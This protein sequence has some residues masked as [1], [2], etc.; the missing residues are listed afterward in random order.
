MRR[1]ALAMIACGLAIM[2]AAAQTPKLDELPAVD[3]QRALN[4]IHKTG[5][6][7]AAA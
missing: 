2:P 7:K 5:G 1:L 6:R 3:Y 4:W